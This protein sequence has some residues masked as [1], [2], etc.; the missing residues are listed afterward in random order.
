MHHLLNCF[1]G[2]QVLLVPENYTET[3][4]VGKC[5]YD[6]SDAAGIAYG[7]VYHVLTMLAATASSHRS[8]EFT[9]PD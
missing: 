1:Q 5:S 9:Q 7:Y 8:S 6:M 4:L 2:Q 3:L